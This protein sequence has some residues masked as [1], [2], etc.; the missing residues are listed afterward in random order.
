MNP[1]LSDDPDEYSTYAL[2]HNPLG[3]KIEG[4]TN[5][6]GRGWPIVMVDGKWVD[7]ETGKPG[8]ACRRCGRPPLPTGEDAC[9]GHIPGAVEACC[10]HGVEDGYILYANGSS[11]VLPRP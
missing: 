7:L 4:T 11:E 1:M 9:L 6:L 5:I 8:R 3:L 10:G 2:A